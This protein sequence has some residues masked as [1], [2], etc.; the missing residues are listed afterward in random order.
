MRSLLKWPLPFLLGFAVA[1]HGGTTLSRAAIAGDLEA[2]KA[3]LKGGEKVNDMDKWGWTV[4]M[5]AVY[6]RTMPV[7]EY[8]L[9]QGADPNIKS[10]YAYNTIANECTPLII[11]GYYGLDEFASVLVKHGAYRDAK[12]ANGKTAGDYAKY[13]HFYS[14]AAII[15]KGKAHGSM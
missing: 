13:Y 15:A 9:Q 2:V 12:D 4:L 14:T 7:T 10:T 8:L 6:Y 3:A 5:W 11:A 1:L